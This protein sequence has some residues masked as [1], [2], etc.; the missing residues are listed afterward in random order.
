VALIGERGQ[1]RIKDF[2]WEKKAKMVDSIYRKAIKRNSKMIKE[3]YK[4]SD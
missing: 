1:K 2:S 4:A 3:K